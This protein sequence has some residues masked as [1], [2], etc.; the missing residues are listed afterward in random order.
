MAMTICVLKIDTV[1]T[2]N[3]AGLFYSKTEDINPLNKFKHGYFRKG[4][5]YQ[6]RAW[7]ARALTDIKG[8]HSS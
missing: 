6:G 8:L 7:V 2:Y 3:I 4:S 5:R 1:K